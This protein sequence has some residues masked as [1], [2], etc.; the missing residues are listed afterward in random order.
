MLNNDEMYVP[1]RKSAVI[2]VNVIMAMLSFFAE[3]AIEM[4]SLLSF[5]LIRLS[6]WLITLYSFTIELE[7]DLPSGG[8]AD[9]YHVDLC[10]GPLTKSLE[11][12]AHTINGTSCEKDTLT[13]LLYSRITSF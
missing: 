11:E 9:T 3:L 13:E 5:R 8:E 1:G 4:L 6:C 10:L 2:K 12:A 7:K